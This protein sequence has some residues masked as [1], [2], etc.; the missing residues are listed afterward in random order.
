MNLRHAL[1]GLG[2]LAAVVLGSLTPAAAQSAPRYFMTEA[3]QW[4]G[5]ATQQKLAE[6]VAKPAQIA[7]EQPAAPKPKPVEWAAQG[8]QTC[9]K[10]HD[11][12]QD[13]SVLHT[14]HGVRGDAKSPMAQHACE[15]CHGPSPEHNNAKPPKGEKRPPV[16]VVFKGEFLSPVAKRNQ[17]CADCHLGGQH[18]NWMGSQ[19]EAAD[20][21]CTDCH[22]A[23]TVKD[24]VMSKKTEPQVC[25]NCHVEQRAQMHQ[26]SHHP[27]PEGKMGCSDCHATHG[28]GGPKLLKG[29]TVNETC[30]TCHAE[31]RGPFLFE[32]EPV[33][34][35]CGNCHLPHGSTQ[36]A[37]LKLRQP[38]LCN[39]CH[40]TS[41]TNHDGL[42]AGGN[43]L[44]GGAGV[45]AINMLIGMGC[46]SCHSKVH[47]SNSPAGGMLTR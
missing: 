12:Q 47:G 10:C 24:P 34:E 16:D 15:S 23:H 25:V 45:G 22:V 27:L 37:L 5:P 33:R 39:Q 43:Q 42:V 44:P 40:Q 38:F 28:S 46:S 19:H 41:R 21:A 14:A 26:L 30:T 9:I 3:V 7:A 32:H 6:A 17:V 2:A 18:I 1:W 8:E 29:M 35:D 13:R 20:V 36:S 4:D 31:T 11:T